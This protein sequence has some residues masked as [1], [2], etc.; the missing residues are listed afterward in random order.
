VSV[1]VGGH[2][3]AGLQKSITIGRRLSNFGKGLTINKEI[4]MPTASLSAS[5]SGKGIQISKS[6]GVAALAPQPTAKVG[7]PGAK[8]MQSQPQQA[9][10]CVK[11]HACRA[12]FILQSS[13]QQGFGTARNSVWL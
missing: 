12:L 1:N 6:I 11:E 7:T 3:S 13:M 5:H 2:A 8:T 10:R 4:A 9:F